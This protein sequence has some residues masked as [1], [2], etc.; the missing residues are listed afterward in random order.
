MKAMFEFTTVKMH[1]TLAAFFTDTASRGSAILADT[2]TIES[3]KK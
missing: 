3:L 1:E 2:D